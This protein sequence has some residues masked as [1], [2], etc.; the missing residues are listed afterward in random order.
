MDR[1]SA[2]AFAGMVRAMTIATPSVA[3]PMMTNSIGVATPSA[4]NTATTT[5]PPTMKAALLTLT[6][7]MTRAR[8]S[9][10]AQACTAA[11][12]GTM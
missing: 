8:R 11:K 9:A 6:A 3:S 5:V 10:P 1:K 4:C 2:S 7:A 12:V